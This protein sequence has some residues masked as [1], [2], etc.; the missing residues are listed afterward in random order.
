MAGGQ[1]PAAASEPWDPAEAKRIKVMADYD[2]YP[3]WALDDGRY[4]NI[5][6]EVLGLS[7]ELTRELLAWGDA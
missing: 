3:L 2:R 4:D 6:P 7:P 5:D 1:G